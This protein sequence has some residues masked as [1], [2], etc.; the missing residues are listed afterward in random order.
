MKLIKMTGTKYIQ[1]HYINAAKISS[2]ETDANGYG[3]Y[4]INITLEGE[5][6]GTLEFDSEEDRDK[7]LQTLLDELESIN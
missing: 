7:R 6:T 2:F 1:N 5:E 4:Y 3:S